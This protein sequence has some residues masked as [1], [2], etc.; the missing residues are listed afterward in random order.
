MQVFPAVLQLMTR[1]RNAQVAPSTTRKY[2]DVLRDD[3]W[4]FPMNVDTIF[5]HT[6]IS[7]ANYCIAEN[8]CLP[9]QRYL[10]ASKF[11]S[12]CAAASLIQ[13]I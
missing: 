12:A 8:L 4:T 7:D 3:Q 1:A 5:G 10:L 9:L 6:G 2:H 13:V 11:H